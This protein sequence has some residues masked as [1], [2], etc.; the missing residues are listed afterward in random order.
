[1]SEAGCRMGGPEGTE[2][3]SR[4][5]VMRWR[6]FVPCKGTMVRSEASFKE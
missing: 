5:A 2:V 1:M 6:F 3:V 4:F